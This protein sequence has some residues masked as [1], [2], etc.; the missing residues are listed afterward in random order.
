MTLQLQ[1]LKDAKTKLSACDVALFANA[2]SSFPQFLR[3]IQVAAFRHLSNL[4]IEF[5]NPVTV[6]AGTNKIGK[7]S[8]LLLIACSYEKFLKADSTSPQG[9]F[10]EHTWSDVLAFTSHE[11]QTADYSYKLWWRV[12]NDN[13]EGEGKRLSSSRAWSGLAKKRGGLFLRP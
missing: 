6:I 8:I 1:N 10:R 2:Q 12:A 9:Q 13:H 11:N 4:E 3:K 7:T 5:T